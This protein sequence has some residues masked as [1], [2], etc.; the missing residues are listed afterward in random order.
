MEQSSVLNYIQEST[1]RSINTSLRFSARSEHLNVGAEPRVTLDLA[2]RI[3][4]AL[5]FAVKEH[6]IK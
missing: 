3:D 6:L 2:V 5:V 1:C 4:I